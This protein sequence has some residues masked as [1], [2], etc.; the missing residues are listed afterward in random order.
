VL[1]AGDESGLRAKSLTP[2]DR[3][4]VTT[5]VAAFGHRDVRIASLE[6]WRPGDLETWRPGQACDAAVAA[7]GLALP[8]KLEAGEQYR[9]ALELS[10]IQP[11]V[12]SVMPSGKAHAGHGR[13]ALARRV[14]SGG[15]ATV[16]PSLADA[17][18]R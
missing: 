16:P 3:D 8:S 13:L 18:D 5:F 9:H 1:R 11:T 12:S 15:S 7:A 17:R 14:T 10:R 4:N 6:T 2:D